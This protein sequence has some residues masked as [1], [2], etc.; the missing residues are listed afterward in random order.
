VP[1]AVRYSSFTPD[2][3][4]AMTTTPDLPPAHRA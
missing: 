1:T 4:V 2:V 3:H